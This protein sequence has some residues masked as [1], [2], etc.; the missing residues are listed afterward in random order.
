MLQSAPSTL[1]LDTWIIS[2]EMYYKNQEYY[3]NARIE[4]ELIIL[5]A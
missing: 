5:R 4:T 2:Q 3:I 1:Y